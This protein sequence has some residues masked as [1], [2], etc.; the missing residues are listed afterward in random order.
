MGNA[1][2]FL[3]TDGTLTKYTGSG[4]E[5]RLPESVTKIGADAFKNC[6]SLTGVVIPRGVT[7]IG[8]NAFWGCENLE[9]IRLPEG[10]LTIG[11]GA[12]CR[13]IRL[14]EVLLPDGITSIGN[15]AFFGCGKLVK[16]R[17]PDG[18]TI[19]EADVFRNCSSLTGITVPESVASIGSLAF[20]GCAKLKDIR[21]PDRPMR[22]DKRG[23]SGTL[24][25]KTPANWKQGVLYI[26]T[27]LIKADPEILSGDYEIREGTKSIAEE[28]FFDID[29]WTRK[30]HRRLTG[31]HIPGSVGIIGA[32]AFLGCSTLTKVTISAGV[33]RIGDGAFEECSGL[34]ELVIPGSVERIG[35]SAF[36]SCSNLTHVVLPEGLSEIAGDTFCGCRNLRDLVI[37]ESV[38]VIGSGAFA[39]C[40]GLTAV[41]LPGQVTSIGEYAFAHCMGL[42]E[43][44]VPDPRCRLGKDIFGDTLPP[45]L[46]SAPEGYHRN[47]PDGSLRKYL[48]TR[49]AWKEIRLATQAGIFLAHQGKTLLPA[50]KACVQDG[51]SLGQEIL[52]RISGAPTAKEC[53]ALAN[54]MILF[55]QSVSDGLLQELYAKLKASEKAIAAIRADGVLMQK[56]RAEADT[57]ASL[58][59]AEQ[60]M[61]GTLERLHLPGSTPEQ[62]LRQKFGLS[63]P[64]LPRVT[65]R[66]GEAASPRVMAYLLTVQYLPHVEH[67][68]IGSHPEAAGILAELDPEDWQNFLRTLAKTHCG[69]TGH[70]KKLSLLEPICRY[71]GETLMEDLAK[72][73]L[74]WPKKDAPALRAFRS[75]SL[76]SPTRASALFAD[77]MGDLPEYA[78][79]RGMTADAYRDGVLWDVGL[80]SRGCKAYDLGG[81]QVA[82]QLQK[83]LRFLILSADGKAFKSLPKKGADPQKYAEAGRDFKRLQRDSEKILQ[84]KVQTLLR[85]FLSG[86]SRT[87]ED[88][89][90]SYLTNPLLR[91]LAGLLVWSQGGTTFTLQGRR[92]I[93]SD[94]SPCP[95]G[96]DPILPAHPMEMAAGEVAAWQ[97]YFISQDLKQ[98]FPQIWEPVI[99]FS[100]VGKGRYRGVSFPLSNFCGQEAQGIYLRL[101]ENGDRRDLE[102]LLADCSLRICGGSAIGQDSLILRGDIRLS[103][104]V[105]HSKSRAANH[106]IALLDE[107]AAQIGVAQDDA[108]ALRRISQFTLPQI[109]ELL[110][111]AI[112]NDAT[113]CADIL[114]HYKNRMLP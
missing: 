104:F 24:C 32:R 106:V 31:L 53:A 38:T 11:S 80:D 12:F 41:A 107:W 27:H 3:I 4:G 56:L 46:L 95:I 70:G 73:A 100:A 5:V 68:A 81:Q 52:R 44:T 62:Y 89:M 112:E 45:Q 34:K 114:L 8:E 64:D 9:R 87:A 91:S 55:G 111:L 29:R 49:E 83:D 10:V 90:A 61:N 108:A 71:A 13:C 37:P 82:A 14:A 76:F 93:C 84:T 48:L 35:H 47:L 92:P 50:Y 96:D 25:Y 113:Y 18:L 72:T 36:R 20:D 65:Y 74:S 69:K 15:A 63:L 19:L 54:F 86:R 33:G 7:A 58:P 42:Q 88:W 110:R 85:E 1:R 102:L 51:Q 99:D 23:F 43:F 67:E 66:N 16:V 28:A 94:G 26:G 105:C 21:L 39:D 103:D 40:A 57:Y 60:R 77:R 2:D 30:T 59:I 78:R 109:E 6:G 101:V 22:I 17:L 98:P 79:L 75:A 97:K